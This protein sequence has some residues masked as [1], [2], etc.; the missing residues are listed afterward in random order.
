[1]LM[2]LNFDQPYQLVRP[3]GQ[4]ADLFVEG[5]VITGPFNL[6]LL[7]SYTADMTGLSV[8]G[9]SGG[10]PACKGYSGY[11]IP[12]SSTTSH[13]LLHLDAGE[14]FSIH[15][16]FFQVVYTPTD[17]LSGFDG[18]G[19]PCISKFRGCDVPLNEI[20]QGWSVVE[21]AN[22]DYLPAGFS[23]VAVPEPATWALLLLGFIALVWMRMR[24][25]Q[26]LL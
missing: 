18:G 5:D 20:P 23:V 2:Q 16:N 4:S 7:D 12:G 6:G 14:I 3:S 9:P 13:G 8:C 24:K 19:N 26:I 21:Y 11:G 1:M 17:R 22:L 25:R 15:L 10:T